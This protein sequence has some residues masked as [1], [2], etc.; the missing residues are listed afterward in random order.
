M[1]NVNR[2]EF[3][4][5]ASGAL[6]AG[7]LLHAAPSSLAIAHYKSPAAAQDAIAEEA[8]RLTRA[9]VDALGG[10]GRFVSKGQ[11]VWIKPN[12][13]WDRRPEQ[14]ACTNPDVVATI[15][16]MCFQAGAGKVFVSDNPCVTP[17]KSF[18]RSGIQAAAQK[19]GAEC[20]YMDDRKFRRMAI[21]GSKI[22]KEWPVYSEIVE[23]DRLINIGI[24]KHHS[25]SKA[26][27]GMKNLMGA[28]GGARD[29]FHQNIGQS[30]VDIAAFLKPQLVVLDAV[31][32]LTA[33]GPTGG[34]LADVKRKDTVIAGVDQVAVDAFG[35]TVLGLK[36]SDIACCVEGQARGLGTMNYQ[37]LSPAMLEI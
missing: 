13:G 2:R 19:A 22:L 17:E 3:L 20:Y 26:A 14:A 37:S 29:R 31:R 7:G 28:A 12:I 6:A 15:V 25:M 34:N 24:V 23:S 16:Q 36:P 18:A 10:M 30:L 4:L 35:A 8:R 32:I 5:G 27:L 33:N 11:K 9:A 1:G 21:K